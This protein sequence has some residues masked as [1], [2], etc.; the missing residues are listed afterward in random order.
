MLHYHIETFSI[1]VPCWHKEP[2]ATARSPK[3]LLALIARSV[4]QECFYMA[5]S[6]R[7][8]FEPAFAPIMGLS[9]QLEDRE[10]LRLITPQHGVYPSID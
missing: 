3:R 4:R 2:F 5:N 9:Y 6:L 8:G 7:A 1:L 10:F